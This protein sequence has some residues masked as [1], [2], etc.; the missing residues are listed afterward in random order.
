MPYQGTPA[1]FSRLA[2]GHGA[3]GTAP[4]IRR[5]SVP[6]DRSSRPSGRLIGKQT[7]PR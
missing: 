1:P 2:G 7:T 4:L 5:R 6:A 3:D